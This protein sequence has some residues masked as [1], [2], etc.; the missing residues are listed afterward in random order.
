M[1][2]K[3]QFRIKLGIL[4][5]NVNFNSSFHVVTSSKLVN[6]I[7]KELC[8]V[9]SCHLKQLPT[10]KYKL[11]LL[12]R[13]LCKSVKTVKLINEQHIVNYEAKWSLP[14]G[15]HWGRVTVYC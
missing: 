14:T 10:G 6:E 9:N 2:D 7:C 5:T 11:S 1:W 3:E 4:N 13:G 8:T 12:K 15:G